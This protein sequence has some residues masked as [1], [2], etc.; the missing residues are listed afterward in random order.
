ML[1]EPR[2]PSGASRMQGLFRVRVEKAPDQSIGGAPEIGGGGAR[3]VGVDDRHD[4][5]EPGLRSQGDEGEGVEGEKQHGEIDRPAAEVAEH[6]AMVP[7]SPGAREIPAIIEA[8]L[9]AFRA[10]RGGAGREV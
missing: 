4:V 10:T 9:C 1:R 7:G 5:L 8:P 6:A 3:S 2:D